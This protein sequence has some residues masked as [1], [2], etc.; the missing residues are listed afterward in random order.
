MTSRKYTHTPR[1]GDKVWDD[2]RSLEDKQPNGKVLWVDFPLREVFVKFYSDDRRRAEY[3]S[4]GLD[5]FFGKYS[6]EY[7]GTWMFYNEVDT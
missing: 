6:P 7:G 1:S 3:E 2:R 4:Y 5:D